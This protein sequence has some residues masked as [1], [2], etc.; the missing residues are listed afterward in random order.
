MEQFA[1]EFQLWFSKVILSV[2]MSGPWSPSD[3]PGWLLSLLLF[4]VSCQESGH[5][6]LCAECG[7]QASVHSSH[8]VDDKTKH[9]EACPESIAPQDGLQPVTFEASLL[10][11][12]GKYSWSSRLLWVVNQRKNRIKTSD[13]SIGDKKCERVVKRIMSE[14]ALKWLQL[15]F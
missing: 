4:L 6:G 12:S 15:A 14:G 11:V 7:A 13:T 3:W 8:S 5:K 1:F 2:V 10:L 9:K